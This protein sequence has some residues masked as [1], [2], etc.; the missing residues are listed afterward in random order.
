M[1]RNSS[2]KPIMNDVIFSQLSLA[3]RVGMGTRLVCCLLLTT[4]VAYESAWAQPSSSERQ[5]YLV[6]VPLPLVGDRDETVRRQINQIAQAASKAKER[7]IVVL[8]FR[9]STTSEARDTGDSMAGLQSRG[10]E[11][12]RCLELARALTSESASRVRLVAYL[13][14]S[15]E[16]HAVLPVLACE[17]ILCAASAELGRAAMDDGKVGEGVKGFYLEKVNQ[18][19]TLPAAVVMSMLTADLA[20]Y[21][22]NTVD[23]EVLFVDQKELAELQKNGKVVSEVTLWP[24]G[25]LASYSGQTMREQGWITRTVNDASELSAAIGIAGT[26][27]KARQMPTE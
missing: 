13:P 15:V 22:V 8:A 5:A 14:N 11:F 27:R 12:G 4:L 18:R 9:A 3:Y 7:P 19:R 10:S 23:G 1:R 25:S 21:K 17:E 16:G 2:T 20:V 26:L 24:G 6:E